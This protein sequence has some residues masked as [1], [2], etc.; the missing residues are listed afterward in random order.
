MDSVPTRRLFAIVIGIDKYGLDDISSLSGAV[1]DARAVAT[2]LQDRLGVHKDH[3]KLLLNESATRNVIIQELQRLAIDPRIQRGDPIV[4]FYAGHGSEASPPPEWE[5][6]GLKAT[7]Q[8]TLPYDVY[9]KSGSEIVMPI[10]DRT[11]GALIDAIA[12]EKANNIVIIMDSC[13][14]A[15]GTRSSVPDLVRSVPPPSDFRLPGSLD[16]DI[17]FS[18]STTSGLQSHVLISACGADGKAREREGRGV[19]TVAML[20]FLEEK[21]KW[22][23]KVRYCDIVMDLDLEG[24]YPHCEGFNRDSYI[25]TTTSPPLN[26]YFFPAYGPKNEYI[27]TGGAAHGLSVGDEFTV[28]DQSPEATASLIP[29]TCGLEPRVTARRAHSLIIQQI[30]S[31]VSIMRLPDEEQSFPTGHHSVARRVKEAK[32]QSL[33]IYGHPGGKLSKVPSLLEEC[34]QDFSNSSILCLAG[35]LKASRQFF[36]ELDRTADFPGITRHI[37]VEISELQ[38]SQSRFPSSPTRELLP[39]N[40]V[41]DENN[42]FTLRQGSSYGLKLTNNSPYDLYPTV[43]YFISDNEF[44]F[45]TLYR[46]GCSRSRLDVPLKKGGGSLTIGYGSGGWP[47]LFIPFSDKEGCGNLK[48]S[49]FSRPLDPFYDVDSVSKKPHQYLKSPWATFLKRVIHSASGTPSPIPDSQQPIKDFILSK[50]TELSP[51]LSRTIASKVHNKSVP[52]I[53]YTPGSLFKERFGR[54]T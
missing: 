48:V 3:I 39:W 26:Q 6:G 46:P 21:D 29:S 27:I 38:K 34:N 54:L 50:P 30:G 12:V 41:S 19:F 9:C 25:F 18:V 23:H 32:R 44:K 35:F 51:K 43:Q 1:A 47:P 52:F 17:R 10:P 7:I 2:Y 49:L 16:Q 31:F 53:D 20:E 8:L 22:L 33:R 14:S 13:H 5:A 40:A 42:S 4:I 37:Q 45:D 11:L 36:S 24:Q 15:S 28:Y